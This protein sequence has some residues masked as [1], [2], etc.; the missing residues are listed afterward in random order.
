MNDD[1]EVIFSRVRGALAPLAKRAAYPAY[2]DDVAVMRDFVDWRDPWAVF[3]ER[4][5]LVNGAGLER[6]GGRGR[7]AQ[8]EPMAAWLLRSQAVAAPRPG[9]RPGVH[10]GDGIR[11]KPCRRLP[12]RNHAGC[13]RDRR[14][15]DDHLVGCINVAP[16]R[17]AH[18]VGACRRAPARG[19]VC[20]VAQAVALL[21]DDPNIIWA[22][23][24]SKTA[25][26]EGILIEGVHGPGRQIALLMA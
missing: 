18:A 6:V 23:G 25:D 22:T 9:L 3:C 2:P 7:P 14:D 12:V 19:G 13:R 4:A 20:N 1:R 8:G 5:K 17:R 15:R 16:A 21:G 11:P 10:G 26:V 24:P